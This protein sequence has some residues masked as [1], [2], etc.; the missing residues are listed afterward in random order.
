M[1]LY[2]AFHPKE[3]LISIDATGDRWG[4]RFVLVL[5]PAP[6]SH[7]LFFS[8]GGSFSWRVRINRIAYDHR[9]LESLSLG[10]VEGPKRSNEEES[11][12]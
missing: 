3:P 4:D 8:G 9:P 11:R 7:R 12:R 10:I 6:S 2:G 1:R 5:R